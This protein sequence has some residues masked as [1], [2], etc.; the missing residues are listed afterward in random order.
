MPA[1]SNVAR[2]NLL[3]ELLSECSRVHD[4]NQLLQILTERLRWILDFARCTVVFCDADQVVVQAFA[5]DDS[6]PSPVPLEE[7]GDRGCR[8]VGR[9]LKPH[10][11]LRSEVAPMPEI[12]APLGSAGRLIGTI[13]FR[14]ETTSYSLADQ[15]IVAYLAD[16][17]GATL[18]RLEQALV[19]SRQTEQLIRDAEERDALLASEHAARMAAEE[20]GRFK[21]QFLAT[22]SHELRTPLNGAAGW[23][24]MI[25]DGIVTGPK[26]EHAWDALDRNLKAELR[27]VEDLLDLSRIITGRFELAIDQVDLQTLVQEAVDSVQAAAA[28]KNIRIAVAARLA[29]ESVR[30]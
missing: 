18:G 10:F 4:Q 16:Y 17:L 23:A 9:T 11:D 29:S 21:D 24:Q 8:I 14:S 2:L 22:L 25:R 7:L 6:T 19:I 3:L 27:L 26:L 30:F 20:A 5:L 12:S 1:G 13:C 15:R 28:A